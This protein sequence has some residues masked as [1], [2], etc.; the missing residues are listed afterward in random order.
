M[1]YQEFR[2][3]YNGQYVD[4]DGYPQLWKWQC[5]D[6]AQLY[7]TECLELPDYILS[8]CENVCNM[9]FWEWK[10]DLLLQYFDE[11]SIY[12][13]RP[14]DLCIWEWNHIAIF[15]SWDGDTNWYFSQNPNPSIVMTIPN[16]NGLHAFRKKKVEP[17]KPDVVP[18][19][20]RDE[21]K[22]QI[23]VKV[24]NLRVRG[25]PTINGDFIGFATPG[26]YDFYETAQNDDYGWY[27]IAEN[28]WVAYD[29]E[30]L[31][32]YYAKEK[33]EYVKFKIL[34]N[35]DGKLEIDLGKV[36]VTE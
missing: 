26:F 8:G 3:K 31:D 27:R 19:V 32:V 9:I 12:D 5:F 13:M 35:E 2:D 25:T 28:Q 36:W 6:L 23:E 10:H 20:E 22:N 34:S 15:D 24:D 29:P 18:N 33:E 1:T 17:P 16:D 4:V 11:V 7:I 21:Y 30:W 14:G